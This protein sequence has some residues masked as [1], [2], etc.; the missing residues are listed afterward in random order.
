MSAL[1]QQ[2]GAINLS[3]GFPDFPVSENLIESVAE[4]MRQG[5]NQ[6]APMAG[7]PLLRER[8][9]SKIQAL[10]QTFPNPDTEMTI[11]PGG[12]YALYTALTTLVQPGDEVIVLEP[13]YDSYVPNIL[14]NGGVPVCVP[15]RYPDYSVDWDRVR[16]AV[17]PRTK[18]IVINTPH[19]PSG[20]VWTP[21]DIAQLRDLIANT[22]LYIV[23]DE[24]YEHITFDGQLHE[25][26]L[27][28]PDLW[29]KALV[30]F[31][32]GKV[33]H[34]TG[35]KIGYCVAPAT[36]THE[37]R[38]IHQFL[39]FTTNTPMQHGLAAFLA[40][41]QEYLQLPN[42]YQQKRDRFLELIRDLPFTV[43]SRSQ[44]TY[45]QM[46]GYERISSLP[47][48]E[49]AVW[50]TEKYGVASIPV[51]AFIHDGRDERMVRFCFGKK[52]ETLLAAAEKLQGLLQ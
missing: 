20:Y 14:T 19:N 4:A 25:S 36:L 1:A 52:E 42:F 6:Y 35:W 11:T 8:L 41:K 27:K 22:G 12:T 43:Y 40:Q 49:F 17:S 44:G 45:F 37:F 51:S 39:C 18:A 33:F 13:A 23:S 38:K 46:L 5:H 2:H 30:I 21:E 10:Y 15:L 48:R 47:D 9:A 29:A 34:A 50:L 26:I 31:S 24:V 7:L 32:F 28:Y 3:Q 16:E